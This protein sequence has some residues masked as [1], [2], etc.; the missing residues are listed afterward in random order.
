MEACAILRASSPYG[1]SPERCTHRVHHHIAK[2][3]LAGARF[4][5][6]HVDS[7]GR[8]LETQAIGP[9]FKRVLAAATVLSIYEDLFKTYSRQAASHE[10]VRNFRFVVEPF[11]VENELLTPTLKLK[12]GA[13]ET[14]HADLIE[15]M[16]AGGT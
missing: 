11:S 15:A 13:I 5:N 14:H 7:E 6:D 8:Q 9:A 3:G 12:R 16:Y 2:L 4:D 1:P 10:K